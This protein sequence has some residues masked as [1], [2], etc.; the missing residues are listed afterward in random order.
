MNIRNLLVQFIDV[1]YR[2]PKFILKHYSLFS[3]I[4][5]NDN[6]YVFMVD[7]KIPHGGMFDRLKG[8]MTIYAIAKVQ[9]KSFKI[10]WTYPFVLE[11]YL[12]PNSYDW[13]VSKEKQ[14]RNYPYTKPIIAYGEIE[15]PRRL[16]KNRSH[17]THFYYGYDNLNEVNKKYS[18]NFDWGSLYR[19]L[20]KPTKYLQ[21]YIDAYQEEIGTN[22]TVIHTRF[23]NLLGDKTET[24]I[25]PE[26]P[27]EE[28]LILMEKIKKEIIDINKQW[29]KSSKCGKVMLASDS[30]IFIDYMVK[31]LPNLYVVPG[32][33]KHIDTAGHTDDSQN[34]KMFVDYYLIAKAAKVYSIYGPR[35][36]KS[37]F[38]EYA[39]KIGNTLFER[40]EII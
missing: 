5:N 13:T 29:T 9:R 19:E 38:P 26:L 7:G 3:R 12:E 27:D 34:I 16:L 22:Y 20:F 14:I 28:K 21:Q 39:A 10:N 11:K 24:S 31:A 33:V 32:E 17:E 2:E 37:A 4:Q 23:L 6:C 40:I 18:S 35:M 15:N 36:W 1:F 25:N 8:I 30:M